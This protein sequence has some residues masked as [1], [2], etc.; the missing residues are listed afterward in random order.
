MNWL[1]FTFRPGAKSPPPKPKRKWSD[2]GLQ[3]RRGF[4]SFFVNPFTC[5]FC[6]LV[7][8]PTRP[9]RNPFSPAPASRLKDLSDKKFVKRSTSHILF[10]APPFLGQHSENQKVLKPAADRSRFFQPSFPAKTEPLRHRLTSPIA[11]G[12][13]DF[14]PVQPPLT[15][16]IIDQSA[17]GPRHDPSSLKTL[18]QPIAD[19]RVGLDRVDG[20]SPHDS[21]HF[22]IHPDAQMDFRPP[23]ETF[24]S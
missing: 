15:Q 14:H 24:E 9:R 11:C 21:G 10:S 8:M 12:T 20:V 5:F 2:P 17:D 4:P 18:S 7:I 23:G 19:F 6:F 3:K 1:P 13:A 22:A 16:Q